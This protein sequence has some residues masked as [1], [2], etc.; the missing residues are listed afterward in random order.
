[1]NPESWFMK[2]LKCVL[3]EC[4]YN[5][6]C[7]SVYVSWYYQNYW[8]VQAQVFVGPQMTPGKVYGWSNIKN[9]PLKKLIFKKIW[10]ANWFL[11][12]LKN[13]DFFKSAK[14]CL[15]L[16]TMY[17]KRNIQKNNVGVKRPKRRWAWSALKA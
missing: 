6:L 9:L 5:L 12:I 14:F 7:L 15:F 16:F 2:N 1:L 10:K 3:H 11:K 13:N 8:T 17:E 4:L